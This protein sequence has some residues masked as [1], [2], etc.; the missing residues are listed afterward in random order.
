MKKKLI[1]AGIIIALLITGIIL[2]SHFVGPKGLIVK[3]QKIVNKKLP[4]SFNGLKIIHFSDL[5][6]GSTIGEKELKK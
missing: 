6:Y 3:E 4:E 5:H 1:I 2:Y